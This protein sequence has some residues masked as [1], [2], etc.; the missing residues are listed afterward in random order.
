[1]DLAGL[2]HRGH[3]Y[4]RGR[5]EK[6]ASVWVR[7]PYVA[8]EQV[9][10]SHGDGSTNPAGGPIPAA[11]AAAVS[12]AASPPPA[13]SPPTTTRVSPAARS[14]KTAAASGSAPGNGC[15]GASR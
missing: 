13:E 9:R 5:Q 14:A 4:A 8:D 15:S 2:E 10:S 1:V 11:R 3:R 6:S 12:T 7:V